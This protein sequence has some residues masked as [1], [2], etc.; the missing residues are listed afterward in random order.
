MKRWKTDEVVSL[1]KNVKSDDLGKMEVVVQGQ[2]GDCDSDNLVVKVKGCEDRLFICGFRTDADIITPDDCE[3]EMV[4]VKDGLDSRGG[5]NSDDETIGYLYVRVRK[6]L[7]GAGFNV[8]NSL[9]EYF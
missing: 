4:E 9:D 2:G 6:A 5:L 8:V 7:I 3:V 1:I